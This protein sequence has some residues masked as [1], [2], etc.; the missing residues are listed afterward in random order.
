VDARAEDPQDKI[1]AGSDA[2]LCHWN[3]RWKQHKLGKVKNFPL[4]RN[5]G[6]RFGLDGDFL[7]TASPVVKLN[8]VKASVPTL[9]VDLNCKYPETERGVATGLAALEEVGTVDEAFLFL[10]DPVGE[11][12]HSILITVSCTNRNS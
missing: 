9:S 11:I 1:L 6:V 7:C 2:E 8:Q 3:L 12:A 5:K 4:A 10:L